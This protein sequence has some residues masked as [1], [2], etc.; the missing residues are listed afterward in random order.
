MTYRRDRKK[1]EKA[2]HSL[3]WDYRLIGG[4]RIDE[5]HGR[6]QRIYAGDWTKGQACGG[7]VNSLKANDRLGPQG[8]EVQN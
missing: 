3:E 8:R 2:I 6:K 4:R 7:D 1:R 5:K